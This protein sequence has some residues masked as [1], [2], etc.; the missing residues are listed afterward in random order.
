MYVGFYVVLFI[1]DLVFLRQSHSIGQ[2]G[3]KLKDVPAS[4][5]PG[6]GLKDKLT[7]P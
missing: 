6:L 3:L 5:S 7:L 4:A 2:A 1:F